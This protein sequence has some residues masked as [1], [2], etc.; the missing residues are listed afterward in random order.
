MEAWI[1]AAAILAVCALAAFFVLKEPRER[2][3]NGPSEPEILERAAAR[4]PNDAPAPPSSLSLPALS[5]GLQRIT[6]IDTETT[7]LTSSD[8]I[9]TFA[10]MR[11]EGPENTEAVYQ[12]YDPRK[13]SNPRATEVHG[14]DDWTLRFQDLFSDTADE[15][16]SWISQS[17]LI[18]AHNAAFDIRF[19]NMEFGL[20]G[21]PPLQNDNVHC[22]MIAARSRWPGSAK[23]DDCVARIGMSRASARHGAL[24]DAYLASVLYFH[25]QGRPITLDPPN[26][27][28]DPS[29]LRPAPPRPIGELPKRKP[30]PQRPHHRRG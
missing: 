18:I 19:L 12:V 23:L 9:I 25:L 3:S 8:R 7:G 29:N 27:W 1:L 28:P 6:V 17:D 16:R 20:C 24:E 22:T 30:K 11:F 10:A 4:T 5:T 13:N 14:W 26:Q 2:S 15:L 21:L